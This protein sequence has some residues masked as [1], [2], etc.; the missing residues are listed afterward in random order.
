MK[1]KLIR[2]TESDLI[3]IIKGAIS[4]IYQHGEEVGKEN[5]VSCYRALVDENDTIHIC[6]PLPFTESRWNVLQGFIHYDDRNAY[7]ITGDVV[8][9]GSEGEPL[10]K[11]IR[12]AK[13]IGKTYRKK[14]I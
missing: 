12:I 11:N 3:G 6:L 10:L 13:K 9:Y 5:G 7:L 14:I 1:N 4:S 2:L 8:G